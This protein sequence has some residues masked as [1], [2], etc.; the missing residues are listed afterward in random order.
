MWSPSVWF[1]RRLVMFGGSE[2]MGV[3]DGGGMVLAG[4]G[5]DLRRGGM[6][7]GLWEGKCVGMWAWTWNEDM[8]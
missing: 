6:L 2:G 8:R 4:E 1:E 5:N 3:G 7:M